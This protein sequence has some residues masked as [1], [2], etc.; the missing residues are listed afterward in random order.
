MQL[1]AVIRTRGDAWRHELQLEDQPA[2]ETHAVFMEALVK[3]GFVVVGGPFDGTAD[4]LLIIRASSPDAIA[5][6]VDDDP[7]TGMGLLR[8]SRIM[9]WT[10]RLGT[11][12][13]E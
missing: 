5:S 11:L 12:P 8:I 4:V 3:E 7:W 9:P 6:R 1:Y 10:I 13:H 2:W